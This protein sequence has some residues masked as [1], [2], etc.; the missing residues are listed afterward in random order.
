M[1]R[2][3]IPQTVRFALICLGV[4]ASAQLLLGLAWADFPL[5]A[6]AVLTALLMWALALRQKW[7]YFTTFVAVVAAVVVLLVQER[8]LAGATVAAGSALVWVPLVI[9]RAWYFPPRRRYGPV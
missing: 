6:S 8:P 3:R 1:A 2:T 7:A 5:V 9:A 4:F